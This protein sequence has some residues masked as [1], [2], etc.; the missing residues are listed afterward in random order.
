MKDSKAMLVELFNN[1]IARSS[2]VAGQGE[3]EILSNEQFVTIAQNAVESIQELLTDIEL[4]TE[5][6]QEKE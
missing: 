1:I 4:E 3:H 6:M 5:K 2:Y